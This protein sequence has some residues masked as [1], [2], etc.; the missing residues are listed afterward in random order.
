[1]KK[2][3]IFVFLLVLNSGVFFGSQEVVEEIIA[4]VNDDVITRSEYEGNLRAIF[5]MLQSQLEGEELTKQ[6]NLMK[7]NLLESMI[8]N[9]LLLQ[10]AREKGFDITEQANLYIENLK[11][12]NNIETDAQLRQE[13]RKQG[14]DFE[15]W[16][17]ELEEN[18]LKQALIFN[19]VD[20]YIVTDDSEIVS[21]YKLHPEEFTEPEEY[22]LRVIYLSSE[23]KNE[24]ELQS[25]KEE[26]SR[27]ISEGEEME[28]LATQYSEGPEKES[29]GDLG[30]FKK[31][32][33]EKNLEEAVEKLNPGEIHPWL[34]ARNGWYLLKLE[35]KKE[36]RIRTFEEVKQEIEK[37][38]FSERKRIK[39]EEYIE[40][41]LKSNYIKIFN[42]PGG[43]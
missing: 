28:D 34:E 43:S 21:Y 3:M 7:E 2:G 9:M 8:R 22:R 40:K 41:L 14:M 17:Q 23:D 12:E 32:E 5:Q 18:F 11:K 10:E 4:I 33:L 35:E 31:G 13:L 1:M 16:R 20:R 29:Q 37:K 19:E 36:S 42:K 38:I 26:I 39:T 6:Y 30:S 25:K 15:A 27:R 24:E